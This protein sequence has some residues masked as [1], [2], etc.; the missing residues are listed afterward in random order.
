MNFSG[1]Q[2]NPRFAAGRFRF[3]PPKGADVI[4]DVSP[5]A[6]VTPLRD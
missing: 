3:T 6:K 1:W 2:R 4:G 5:G